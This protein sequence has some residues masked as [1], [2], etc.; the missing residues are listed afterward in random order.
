MF[1]NSSVFL[2]VSQRRPHTPERLSNCVQFERRGVERQTSN[3]RDRELEKRSSAKIAALNNL[4][5]W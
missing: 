4:R 2:R 5:R 1:N 3:S